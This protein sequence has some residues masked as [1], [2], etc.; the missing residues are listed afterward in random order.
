MGKFL[1][2]AFVV[3][4]QVDCCL[5]TCTATKSLAKWY[6]LSSEDHNSVHGQTDFIIQLTDHQRVV[7]DGYEA[8]AASQAMGYVLEYLMISAEGKML[9]EPIVEY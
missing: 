2:P 9:F 1:A 6:R 8:A 3:I 4:E 7:K 5:L